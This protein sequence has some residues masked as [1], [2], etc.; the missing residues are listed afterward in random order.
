MGEKISFLIAAHNEEKMIK[1]VL[2][3]L[4][5]LPYKNFE[6]VV[7]LDGCTDRTLDIVKMFSKKLH[8]LRYFSFNQRRGKNVI[9]NKAIK[10]ATGDIIIIHDADWVF[11][12]NKNGIEKLISCFRNPKIG[13]I[14]ES[15][16][17]E[18]KKNFSRGNFWYRG[19]MWFNYLWIEYLKKNY[20]K[21]VGNMLFVDKKKLKFPFLTNIFKRKLFLKKT[22][23]TSPQRLRMLFR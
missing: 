23:P 21:R 20:T 7:G 19:S 9:I 11:K 14:A 18:F 6:V 8:K 10:L 13:G 22:F 12:Y 16:P 1:Y 4:A 15:F 3:N 2:S 5:K 17:V